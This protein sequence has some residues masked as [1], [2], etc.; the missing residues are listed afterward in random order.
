MCNIIDNLCIC[1]A[2]NHNILMY[3]LIINFCFI[4]VKYF[5]RNISLRLVPNCITWCNWCCVVCTT[6]EMVLVQSFAKWLLRMSIDSWLTFECTSQKMLCRYVYS[7]SRYLKWRIV[8]DM[9]LPPQ[10][11]VV[12]PES[13]LI[14]QVLTTK[15]GFEVQRWV[16]SQ[17][18]FVTT[19]LQTPVYTMFVVY[20]IKSCITF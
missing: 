14:A 20:W 9:E 2:Y 17:M 7:Y 16:I 11:H 4:C 6:D 10:E 13:P 1:N 15:S 3:V 12:K 19:I 5:I 8:Y 18:T